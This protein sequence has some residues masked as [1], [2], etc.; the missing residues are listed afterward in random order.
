MSAFKQEFKKRHTFLAVIH[1]QNRDQML[2]NVDIARK[3]GADGVFL[4]NHDIDSSQLLY[5][6]EEAR[7]RHPSWWIGLN[8]LGLS[9]GDAQKLLPEDASGLWTDYAGVTDEG[10]VQEASN[11]HKI[12]TQWRGLYFGGVAFKYQSPVTDF[13]KVARY[14]IEY[15]DVITTSGEATGSAPP[16]EKIITMRK[17]AGVHPL[18]IA[19]GMT[20]EN[21][22]AYLPY[23]DC[24]LVATGISD[25]HTELNATRTK[26]FSRRVNS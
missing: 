5:C 26:E 9:A 16:L 22:S 1:V 2:R 20:P 18:A 17:G 13:E 7:K 4:I 21:V 6:Y 14:A 24:F 11:F 23:V 12:D 25:S 19:S 3:N 10:N 8:I 15:V